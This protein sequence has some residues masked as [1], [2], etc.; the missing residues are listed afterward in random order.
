M[1][2]LLGDRQVKQCS[3]VSQSIEAHEA[4]MS[5]PEEEEPPSAVSLDLR[6]QWVLLTCM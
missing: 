1:A 3:Y 6:V 2:F 4:H 5:G